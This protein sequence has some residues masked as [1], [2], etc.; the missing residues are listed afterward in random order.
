M[1]ILNPND[2][3]FAPFVSDLEHKL[4]SS[5]GSQPITIQGSDEDRK[6]SPSGLL[7]EPS[8]NRPT[9]QTN[10]SKMGGSK[11]L[12]FEFRVLE[13]CLKFVCKGLESETSTLEQEAYPALDK[14]SISISMLNLQ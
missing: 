4:S 2:P 13:I 3:G 8:D 5:D 14:L 10:T 11:V 1:L 7:P 6:H 12:P 9:N